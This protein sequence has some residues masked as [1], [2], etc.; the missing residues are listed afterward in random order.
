[1]NHYG[2]I[3]ME[4]TQDNAPEHFAKIEDP[5]TYFTEAG[6]EIAEQIAEALRQIVGEPAPGESLEDYRRRSSRSLRQAEEIVLADHYRLTAPP[7]TDDEPDTTGDPALAAYYRDLA[8]V[9]ETI[10]NLYR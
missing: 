4:Y 5:E 1:M 8:E 6:E 9:N 7:E 2:Q 3:A 10:A